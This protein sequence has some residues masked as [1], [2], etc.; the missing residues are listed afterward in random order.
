M[1]HARDRKKILESLHKVPSLW[2][3][4]I[5][6]SR[7]K[8][9]LMHVLKHFFRVA[10]ESIWKWRQW[11]RSV[12]PIRSIYRIRLSGCPFQRSS[13]AERPDVRF[14]IESRRRSRNRRAW[15]TNAI[16][17]SNRLETAK[18]LPTIAGRFRVEFRSRSQCFDDKQRDGRWPSTKDNKNIIF[19][20]CVFPLFIWQKSSTNKSLRECQFLTFVNEP[21][22]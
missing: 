2:K 11:I 12:K 9:F 19:G 4:T 20:R 16:Y 7:R 10:S 8:F 1:F 22:F 6:S 17:Q 3:R 5:P 18:R 21:F 15:E 14:V 13:P